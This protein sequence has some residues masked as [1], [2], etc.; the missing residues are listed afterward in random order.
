MTFTIEEI[1]NFTP[2]E[3]EF[4]HKRMDYYDVFHYSNFFAPLNEYLEGLRDML[5]KHAKDIPDIVRKE[6]FIFN[7]LGKDYSN[8][9]FHKLNF[10]QKYHI[11]AFDIFKKY[12]ETNKSHVLMRY[13]HDEYLYEQ[14]WFV[15]SINEHC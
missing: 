13:I 6:L 14:I 7:L 8:E 11:M 12:Y 1:N 15:H 2:Q 5:I 3:L 9:E 4:L 10:E